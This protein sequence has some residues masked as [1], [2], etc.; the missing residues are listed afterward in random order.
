MVQEILLGLKNLDDQARSGR[1]KSVDSKA[2]L[3]AIE[4]NMVSNIQRVS[5]ELGISESSVFN[6]SIWN[7]RIVP[8]IIKI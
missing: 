5:G 1:P 6:K 8:H 3:Q 4:E 7:S 2:V